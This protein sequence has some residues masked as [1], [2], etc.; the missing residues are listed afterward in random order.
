MILFS[1]IV[2]LGC[3]TDET[4]PNGL[5]ALQLDEK[6]GEV[7]VKVLYNEQEA[8]VRGLV[9]FAGPYYRWQDLR[10]HVSRTI[11]R[12]GDLK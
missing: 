6:S 8:K 9:P 2:Y 5:K 1:M 7:L 11:E 10:E 4:H 12:I 3:Y